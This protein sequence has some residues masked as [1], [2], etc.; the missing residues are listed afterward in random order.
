MDDNICVHFLCSL[1][2]SKN[3]AAR[4]I[5]KTQGGSECEATDVIVRTS[6]GSDSDD[7][8]QA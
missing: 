7:K 8:D 4:V 1:V 5:V 2:I 3:E 6:G